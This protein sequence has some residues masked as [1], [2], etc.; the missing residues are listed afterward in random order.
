LG[1]WQY[2][3]TTRVAAW[4]LSLILALAVVTFGLMANAVN[5]GGDI[6]HPEIRTV[7][8]VPT[9]RL[10][11]QVGLALTNAPWGWPSCETIRLVGRSQ[12][13]VLY[14]AGCR[15]GNS[16][17]RRCPVH[18][19][20]GRRFRAGVVGGRHVFRQHVAVH[21]ECVLMP[22]AL[23]VVLVVAAVTAV[24]AGAGYLI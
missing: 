10:A 3:R 14:D 13:A 11:R 6:H 16:L 4:N 21:R 7:P 9:D 23:A 17:W 1:L 2:R 8:D 12:H 19:Q 22:L 5:I 20:T 18:R 15:L 24:F